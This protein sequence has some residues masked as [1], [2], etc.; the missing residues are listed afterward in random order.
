MTNV[1][2]I[3]SPEITP[4]MVDAGARLA[5]TKFSGLFSP[6]VERD[7]SLGDCDGV[8]ELVQAL[9]QAANSYREVPAPAGKARRQ[10]S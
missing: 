6:Y 2:V 9:Y 4:E 8:R 1:K 7:F 3:L 5:L 10:P